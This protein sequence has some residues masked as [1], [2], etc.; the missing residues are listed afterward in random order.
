MASSLKINFSNLKGVIPLAIS[1]AIAKSILA[2]GSLVLAKVYG[3]EHFGLYNSILSIGS[4]FTV[5]IAFNLDSIIMLLSGKEETNSFFFGIFLASTF[6]TVIAL[7]VLL[8]TK[9]SNLFIINNSYTILLI[10]GL[11]SWLTAIN[12]SQ[13]S[14][15]TK[16]KEYYKISILIIL[17]PTATVGFQYIFYQTNWKANG[18][19][20]GW[21]IGLLFTALY[22]LSV[23]IKNMKNFSISSFS[24]TIKKYSNIIKHSYSASIIDVITNNCF[25]ILTLIYFSASEVGVY[26]L[27]CK[28]L[29][30]PLSI[31][32]AS[33]L[34][35][36][37]E[38]A[39]K[40]HH[41][42]PLELIKL[43][44]SIILINI[45]IVLFFV[46]VVN[47]VGFYILEMYLDKREWINLE[48]YILI[49]SFW[50]LS[51]A[52]VNP[53]SSVVSV[54]NK[55]RWSLIFNTFLLF[56]SILSLYIGIK[57]QNF[58]YCIATQSLLS[59]I[60]YFILLIAI[61]KN[62]KENVRKK[63]G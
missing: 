5:F 44:K 24:T 63:I 29:M 33:F 12:N 36:Y 59:S 61:L 15:L 53:I 2:I 23:S 42:A 14:L 4:I 19:L 25:I 27:A 37:A 48:Y 8:L 16:N 45:G 38:K 39:V 13:I 1:N 3:P 10:I 55:N 11:A 52:L 30:A 58:L 28:I 50:I 17:L 41:E 9:Y 49:L 34:K 26:A 56:T 18:L 40:L 22:G 35:F 32:S 57:F 60:G 46:V 21:S 6:S 20:Y 47:T 31:L 62:L 54:I 43:T 51:R 7:A